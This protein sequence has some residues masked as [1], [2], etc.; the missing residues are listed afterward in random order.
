MFV[1]VADFKFFFLFN[2]FN[3]SFVCLLF[4]IFVARALFVL[5]CFFSFPIAS[6]SL[7]VLVVVVAV[8]VVVFVVN[9]VLPKSN[10][11]RGEEGLVAGDDGSSSSSFLF[12]FLKFGDGVAITMPFSFW[13]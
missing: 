7:R 4:R 6:F 1:S 8:V 3:G 12:S 13:S 11:V 5:R 9:V 2:L 10:F